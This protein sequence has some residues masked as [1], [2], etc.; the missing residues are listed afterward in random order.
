M[1]DLNEI[2]RSGEKA[3]ASLDALCNVMRDLVGHIP[4]RRRLAKGLRKHKRK[5]KAELRCLTSC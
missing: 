3:A 5:I 1:F 2:V 4:R